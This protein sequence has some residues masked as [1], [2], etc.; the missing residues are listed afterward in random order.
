MK[1]F[2]C[3]ANVGPNGDISTMKCEQQ[4][5]VAARAQRGHIQRRMKKNN[6]QLSDNVITQLPYS[7]TSPGNYRLEGEFLFSDAS[8]SAITI[9]NTENVVLDFQGSKITTNVASFSPLVAV[10]DSSKVQLKNLDLEATDAG[11]FER[12]GLNV[13]QCSDVQVKSAYIVNL[14]GAFNFSNSEKDQKIGYLFTYTDNIKIDKLT[15][16]NDY[17]IPYSSS[18]SGF[19]GGSMVNMTDSRIVNHR[20]LINNVTDAFCTGV[21]IDNAG[22]LN[23][24]RGLQ[25]ESSDFDDTKGENIKIVNCTIRTKNNLPVLLAD[26]SS[27][28]RG[29]NNVLLQNNTIELI[30]GGGFIAAI[31]LQHA[32]NN[33]VKN[34]TIKTDGLNALGLLL[35][36]SSNNTIENNSVSCV[37][38]PFGAIGAEG[39]GPTDNNIVQNNICSSDGSSG[40]YLGYS[41]GCYACSR[42][43]GQANYNEFIKNTVTGFTIG[44]TDYSFDVNLDW[45]YPATYTV[46]EK[47]C[48]S[49][50]GDNYLIETGSTAFPVYSLDIQNS[51]NCPV[52]VLAQKKKPTNDVPFDRKGSLEASKD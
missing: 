6:V 10:S 1:N 51:E 9:S 35:L 19:L 2:V 34:N 25:I 48:A 24:L 26:F 49:G 12:G 18:I 31:W 20:L 8:Q 42:P 4:N 47:N 32:D 52:K 23:P 17:D 27:D 37:N 21:I 46:F 43:S 14:C 40:S 30:N 39:S 29:L 15:Q 45:A 3:V 16:I 36:V 50:N 7:I 44:I 38:D 28:L 33:I 41:I 13:Y 22:A 11:R 5:S